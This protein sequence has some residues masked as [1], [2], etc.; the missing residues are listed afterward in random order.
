MFGRLILPSD[1]V[2]TLR[3][4]RFAMAEARDCLRWKQADDAL[5]DSMP[6]RNIA[7]F[8][9]DPRS[10]PRFQE[11]ERKQGNKQDGKEPDRKLRRSSNRIYEYLAAPHNGL[12]DQH[13]PAGALSAVAI[14]KFKLSVSQ[15]E[16]ADVGIVS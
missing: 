6:A 12:I 5:Q 9:S 4:Q 13:L 16:N 1:A 14:L 3:E 7:A 10:V 8:C 15:L 11:I 2:Q